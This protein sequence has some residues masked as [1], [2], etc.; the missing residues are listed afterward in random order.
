MGPPPKYLIQ[1][2][3]ITKFMAEEVVPNKPLIPP[4]Y[5]T[6]VFECW[7]KFGPSNPK[8]K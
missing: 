3:L 4:Y 8:C 1:R 5:F 2:K 7:K 6:R